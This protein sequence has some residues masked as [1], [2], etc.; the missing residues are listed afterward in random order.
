MCR[1]YTDKSLSEKSHVEFMQCRRLD[2]THVYLPRIFGSVQ[3]ASSNE[4][5]SNIVTFVGDWLGF[6]YHQVVVI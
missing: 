3:F 4:K 1:R 6:L 5:C 2:L